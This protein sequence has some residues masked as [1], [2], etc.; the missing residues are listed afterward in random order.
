MHRFTRWYHLLLSGLLLLGPTVAQAQI[1]AKEATP[2][3]PKN[4]DSV[5]EIIKAGFNI[6]IMVSGVIF[7]VLL[8]VGGVMYLTAM[9]NDDQS[10]KAKQ[11]IFDAVV[12][13]VLVV[14]AWAVG[15]W[16]LSLLGIKVDSNAFPTN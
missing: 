12:G 13:L 4:F 16:V 8:L 14:V 11:L 9:G 7:V 6:V 2:T 5:P 15:N 3:L 10:K 1:I